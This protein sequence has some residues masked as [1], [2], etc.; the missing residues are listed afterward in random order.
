MGV[1][2]GILK[3]KTS[4]IEQ[5]KTEKPSVTGF[6]RYSNTFFVTIV[7]PLMLLSSIYLLLFFVLN[8]SL[9]PKVLHGQLSNFLRGDYS[10]A[11]MKTDAWL[12][13]LTMTDV[14]LAEAG[15]E[16]SNYVIFVP[17][18]EAKIPILELTE[19]SHS[20]L[21]VGRIKA[22]DAQVILDFTRGELN[23]LKV[24]LPYASEPE[25]P[26]PPG[27][28]K[29]WLA[30]L[31]TDKA[32][33]FLKFDGF[34]IDLYGC[35]VLNYDLQA[36]GGILSMETP[37]WNPEKPFPIKV[38]HG[39]VIFDPAT[40]S[41]P[42][43]DIGDKRE[44]LIFS[45]GPGSAGK[46]GYSYAQM[47]RHMENMLR[48]EPTWQDKVGKAPEM[49][50]EFVVP[51]RNTLIE[52]FIWKGNR[53]DIPGMETEVGENGMLRMEHAFMNVGPTQKDMD[54]SV[55]NYGYRLSDT[56]P[57]ETILWDASIDLDLPVEDPIFAYFFGPIMHGDTR[58]NLRAALGGDLGRVS[59]D[60]ALTTGALETFGVDLKRVDLRG[61]MD[62]QD[63]NILALQADTSMGSALV[64]GHYFIMDGDFDFD[65]WAGKAPSA[66]D[67]A[68]IEAPRPQLRKK[69]P[70]NSIMNQLSESVKLEPEFLARLEAGMDPMVMVNNSAARPYA[71]IL[72][73]HIKASSKDG[74][75]GVSMPDPVVYTFKDAVAGFKKVKISSETGD[76]QFVSYQD[77]VV[78][79]PGGIRIEAG[80]DRV[81]IKPGMSINTADLSKMNVEVNA[82]IE[83]PTRYTSMVGLEDIEATPIDLS[84][85]I[86]T[87]TSN[88]Y[89][90]LILS[91]RNLRYGDWLIRSIGIDMSLIDG[92]LKTNR[93]EV[94]TDFA[95]LKGNVTANMTSAML[96]HPKT[97]PFNAKL[98]V[99]DIDFDELPI[100]ALDEFGLHGVA[101][102]EITA[103]GPI[104]KLKGELVYQ[105]DNFE[106]L[107]ETFGRL[108]L[109]AGYDDNVASIPSLNIWFD[110]LKEDER[111]R[112]DFTIN[113]LT[114]KLNE[115]V[116]AFNTALQPVSPN[117][118]GFI[119]DMELPIEVEAGFDLTAQ[120][121]L[122]VLN[123]VFKMDI[124][125]LKDGVSRTN[126]DSTWV[127]GTIRLADLKYETMNLGT[128]E[129]QMSRANQFVLVKGALFGT[130]DENG[131]VTSPLGLSG[132][133]RT[134][135]D[136]G[137]S[138]SINFP[139]LDV[140]ALLDRIGID[141]GDTIKTKFETKSAMMAG[142][143]G[144]C[145]TTLDK[146]SLSLI[147]DRFDAE[148]LH[149]K[150]SLAQPLIAQFD[151]DQMAAKLVQLEMKFRDSTLKLSGTGDLN[152]NVALDMNGE[153]DAALARSLSPE[154]VSKASGLLGVS[155]SVSGNY[156]DKN[157]DISLSDLV[158]SG[159]LGV[160]DMIQVQTSVANE[161]IYLERGF[162]VIDDKS[163]RCNR[164]KKEVCLYTPDDLPF[165]LRM[166]DETVKLNLFASSGGRA[167][168]GL[169]GILGA[170]IAKIFVKDISSATGQVHVDLGVSG[171]VLDHGQVNTDLSTYEVVG[172]VGVK[173]PIIIEMNSLSEPIEVKQG[174]IVIAKGSECSLGTECLSIPKAQAF[175]GNLM[176]GS[177]IIFGE[178]AR[179]ALML[180]G[181][182]V[183]LTA[184]NVNFRMKDE[185][186]LTLSPDIQVTADDVLGLENVVIAGNVDVAEARYRR[187]FDDGNSNL[188]KDMILSYFVDSKKRVSTYSPSFLRKNPQLGKV[189]LDVS[190]AAE[191]SINVDVKIANASV[192]LELGTQLK[193]GGTIKDFLPTGILSI[194]EGAIGFNDNAFEFQSG[195][196]VAFNNSLDGK[197]D[198]VATAEINTESTA[199][200]SV[201]GSS[202]D[203][204]RRKR[205]STS[206]AN[207]NSTLYSITLNV[208]GSVFSPQWSF[209]SSPYLTD[210]N[211]YALILT[212]RSI[213]D[214]SG[215]DMAMESLLSPLFSSQ[216]DTF[217]NAD[218]FKFLFSDGAAQFVYAKQITKGLR[219]AAGVSIKGVEGNE[220][221]LSAEYYFNDSWFIDLTG[222][223]TA[224]EVGRA[225][226]FKLGARLHWHL[227][228]DD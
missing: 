124:D 142:S 177:F 193:I 30:D 67:L 115:K 3:R 43:S 223:N 98:N 44:G 32:D 209:D 26:T 108:R 4:K 150:L 160:R 225:P 34:H 93:F 54:E 59:G 102:A 220:Q 86:S 90:R 210:T 216:L 58:A 135:R 15:T 105:M 6:S 88:P 25:P 81:V 200:S 1:V 79:S 107:D 8:T 48:D 144:F 85:A 97:I 13:T 37:T 155:L 62:G 116:V 17:K 173:A 201:L 18:V 184:N 47:T 154:T 148:V 12:N 7:W 50:G 178:V 57:E 146:M 125:Y 76:S 2:L 96:N 72:N 197:I 137:A 117:R 224:D 211:I 190:V 119:R 161:P 169:H 136:L 227:P 82:H 106:V 157:K 163:P 60:L 133:V 221:A 130:E 91:T 27:K 196:Q 203:L 56:L 55:K 83:E 123:D 45:G 31:N 168:V 145:M 174:E 195:S 222:Q 24:V 100:E 186:S 228:L 128:T 94:N 198:I 143:I 189:A 170:G 28:F 66:A 121:D 92:A 35:D 11:T 219:V 171:N 147:L 71:G 49:R 167:E 80:D 120:A 23:I 118:F 16:Y 208:G 29:V 53:F 141:L 214:F 73:T 40:F 138:L 181:G 20:T 46:L 42:L 217:V 74:K 75:M 127:E 149:D 111:R 139:N 10:C 51:I 199:F 185:L 176:G 183:S 153:I 182:A 158:M 126:M 140:L 213:E 5:A 114:Y 61:H 19:L 215:N 14:R 99:T 172:G 159:Y 69:M 132:Y 192:D 202:T 89:G 21:K 36:G 187:N 131:V 212:G 33:V 206:D 103:T 113:A 122:H 64:S 180:K 22:Y 151:L 112:P 95:R 162:F 52:G 68:A 109:R 101:T 39:N 164:A 65:V 194:S 134:A 175:S 207:S 165:T 204:D 63:M 156:Y 188:I 152:G 87:E 218:Q 41:F 166:H 179:E 78:S 226:T 104:D 38:D 9:G 84:A 205:I 191:N 70:K 110:P 129:L 77:S